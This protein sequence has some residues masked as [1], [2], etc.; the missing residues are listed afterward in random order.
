MSKSCTKDVS[1]AEC[2]T[3]RPERRLRN[4]VCMECMI[5]CREYVIARTEH[6]IVRRERMI[7]HLNCGFVRLDR[8]RF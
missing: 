2:L 4:I 6:I 5:V 7:M 1:L 8:R 3:E